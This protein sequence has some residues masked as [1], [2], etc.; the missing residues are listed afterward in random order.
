MCL[1]GFVGVSVGVK[2]KNSDTEQRTR[3]R[4]SVNTVEQCVGRATPNRRR[5]SGRA[6]GGPHIYQKDTPN[7]KRSF[8]L[9]H[10]CFSF[11]E[12]AL[13]VALFVPVDMADHPAI[14]D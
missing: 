14:R 12:F 8:S 10:T 9:E 2:G 4:Q 1:K 5:G 13:R 7:Q 11:L 3:R 6:P